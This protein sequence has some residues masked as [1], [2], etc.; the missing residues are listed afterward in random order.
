MTDTSSN[1]AVFAR[2][3]PSVWIQSPWVDAC[4]FI[5]VPLFLAPLIFAAPNRPG[6]Q[7]LI[8]YLGAFGALGHHLPGMLRA[9]GDRELFRRFRARLV[10]APIFLVLVCVTF[11]LRG[12]GAVVLITFLWTTWH[13]LM[14]VYGFARIYDA[15]VGSVSRWTSRLDHALCAAWIVAPLIYS[16]SRVAYALEIYYRCGAPLIPAGALQTARAAWLVL[17]LALTIAFVARLALSWSRGTRPNPVKLLFLSMSF[18]FWWFCMAAVDHLVAGIALFDVFHDVQYLALVWM[19]QRSRTQKADGV[20]GFTRFLFRS[21][22]SLIGLYVGMVVAYGSLGYFSGLVAS[23]TVR[24]VLLGLLAASALFHFYLD[25]FIWKVREREM[26]E[27]LGIASESPQASPALRLPPWTRH[28]WKW[29]LFI[30]PLC[31]LAYSETSRTADPSLWRAS[32]AELTPNSAEALTSYGVFLATNG[33]VE[34][35][36]ALHRRATLLKPSAPEPHNN[37]GVA[38]RL[39]GKSAQARVCFEEAI[40]LRPSYARAHGHLANL[41]VQQNEIALAEQH[42]REA[43]RYDAHYAD[44]RANLAALLSGRGDVAAALPLFRAALAIE[45]D[46]RGALNNLAWT[47]ATTSRPSLRAQEEALALALRFD[48][49]TEHR[50]AQALDTLAAAQAANG[51]FEAAERTSGEAIEAA[52]AKDDQTLASQIEAHRASYRVGRALELP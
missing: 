44:P 28:A 3:A 2:R 29:G 20:T 32:I 13:T 25:G 49:L 18:G 5:G 24:D 41:L 40:F 7:E 1:P 39:Q 17:T 30:V 51:Q 38:L 6:V 48:R 26:R 15:K 47:L 23:E 9:Y 31:V 43:I 12:L 10:L 37:L 16:D 33:D 36:I 22:G 14:Q 4:L 46:N 19:F 11:S 34:R 35:A 8:L 27:S 45:P 21:S 52:R 50:V 42:F